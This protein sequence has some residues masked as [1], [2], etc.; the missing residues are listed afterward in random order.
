MSASCTPTFQEDRLIH[1]TC[2]YFER[3]VSSFWLRDM[4]ELFNLANYLAELS[5]MNKLLH[6]CKNEERSI[7]GARSLELF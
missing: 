6:E 1:Q 7:I 3:L 4:K 2:K 5:E